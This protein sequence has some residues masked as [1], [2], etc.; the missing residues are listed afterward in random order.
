V[1]ARGGP[2]GDDVRLSYRTELEGSHW[3]WRI[4][5]NNTVILQGLAPT[6]AESVAS[7]RELQLFI[8]APQLS[9]ITREA[10]AREAYTSRSPPI[11][12]ATVV[13]SRAERY[14]QL[15]RA[16]LQL[17]NMFPGGVSRATLIEMAHEWAR[18]VEEEDPAAA[19]EE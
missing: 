6:R 19:M 4:F 9:R 7:V 18:L 13:T 11:K 3:R 16:C 2:Q 17:A 14:C 12:R 5:S 1:R 8:R 15:A 10:L